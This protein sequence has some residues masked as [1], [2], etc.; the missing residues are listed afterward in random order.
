MILLSS[1][2]YILKILDGYFVDDLLD[3]FLKLCFVLTESSSYKCKNRRKDS[4][5]VKSITSQS[6]DGKKANCLYNTTNIHE[7]IFIDK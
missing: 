1:L 5:D 2:N 4:V 3:A 7:Y 6:S